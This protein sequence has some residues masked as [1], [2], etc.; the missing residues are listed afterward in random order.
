MVWRLRLP[1]VWNLACSGGVVLS[2]VW[3]VRLVWVGLLALWAWVTGFGFGVVA[4]G[5]FGSGFSFCSFEGCGV[6]GGGVVVLGWPVIFGRVDI[7]CLVVLL[8]VGVG[9]LCR[10]WFA[11]LY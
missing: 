2:G 4:L 7:M 9:F 3:L 8:V 11:V 1:I 10:V 5:T 6:C